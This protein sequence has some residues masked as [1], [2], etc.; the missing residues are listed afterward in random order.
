MSGHVLRWVGCGLLLLAGGSGSEIRL[1]SGKAQAVLGFDQKENDRPQIRLSSAVRVTFT[2]EGLSPVEVNP[3][4][5]ESE[6][7]QARPLSPPEVEKLGGERERWRQSF[8]LSPFTP[9]KEVVL[10]LVPLQYRE[11]DGPLQDA[12][13]K[14]IAVG[15]LTRWTNPTLADAED[16]T[17]IEELPPDEGVSFVAI[18]IWAGSTLLTA[19]MVALLAWRAS[20]W[21]RRPRPKLPPERVASSE[22]DR[23]LALDLPGQGEAG[24]F[25]TALGDIVRRYLDERYG[26]QTLRQ[27]TAE[28]LGAVRQA[29]AVAEEQ[30]E[31]LR[32]FLEAC[33]RVKFSGAP[34]TTSE[35]QSAADEVRKIV[36][37]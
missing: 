3:W 6:H 37:S 30:R 24:R 33:D 9:G 25:F 8:R 27:T 7:W 2:V 14:P 17:P 26:L 21:R 12:S 34:A 18:L 16:I 35:C 20:R 1:Q 22:L 5:M 15:V 32:G 13:W 29:A 31:R 11:E 10:Q 4:K 19:G 28:C 23:L 36:A